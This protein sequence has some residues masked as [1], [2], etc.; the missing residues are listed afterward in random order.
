MKS[1]MR[2]H[3]SEDSQPYTNVLLCIMITVSIQ[4]CPF[5]SLGEKAD[6]QTGLL[7]RLLLLRIQWACWTVWP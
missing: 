6:S 5:Q 2:G 4:P 7:S 3:E 1:R